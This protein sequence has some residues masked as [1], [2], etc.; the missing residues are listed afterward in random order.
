MKLEQKYLALIQEA[1][2]RKLPD[3]EGIRL[4]FQTLS[5]SAAIDRDCAALL[6]PHGLSEGRFVLLFL[7]DAAPDG[8]AP[9]TLARAWAAG[10]NPGA[11]L[12]ANDGHGF[13][14]ALG[15]SVITG[16]TLTNVNDFRA[17]L[18]EGGEGGPAQQP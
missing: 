8:L 14:Q 1:K 16:P 13:F 10:I 18:I 4:C 11:S 7:L 17:I 2:R 12:D 5:L 6:A 15:D 3:V 9:N